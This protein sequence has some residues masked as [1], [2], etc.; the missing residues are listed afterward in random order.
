MVR[1]GRAQCR[2]PRAL[3]PGKPILKLK[4]M[5]EPASNPILRGCR[6]RR[7]LFL[8]NQKNDLIV[9]ALRSPEPICGIEPWKRP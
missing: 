3:N 5:T 9:L 6:L 8:T 7:D 1:T 4:F 2:S